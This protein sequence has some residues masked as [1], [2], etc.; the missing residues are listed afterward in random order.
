MFYGAVPFL[1][2][3]QVTAGVSAERAR[4][5]LQGLAQ[6][7]PFAALSMASVTW[8]TC[9]S[10]GRAVFVFWF[11]WCAKWEAFDEPA[12]ETAGFFAAA[13]GGGSKVIAHFGDVLVGLAQAWLFLSVSSSEQELWPAL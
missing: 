7:R 11:A 1:C 6:K 13:G 12:R 2:I 5:S 10:V 3:A 9:S 8:C 4:T